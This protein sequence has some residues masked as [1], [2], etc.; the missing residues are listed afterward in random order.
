MYAGKTAETE[1]TVTARVGN[2]ADSRTVQVA[3]PVGAAAGD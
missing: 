3:E 1:P 2:I